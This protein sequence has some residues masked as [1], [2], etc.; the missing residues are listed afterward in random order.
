MGNYGGVRRDGLTLEEVSKAAVGVLDHAFPGVFVV[1]TTPHGMSVDTTT[2][3]PILGWYPSDVYPGFIGGR[4]PDYGQFG[5]W[6]L[7]V[8]QT[9]IAWKLNAHVYDEGVGYFDTNR[10]KEGAANTFDAYIKR[11]HRG[12]FTRAISN[13]LCIERP[14]IP[15]IL[16]PYFDGK[17]IPDADSSSYNPP[18]IPDDEGGC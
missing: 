6:L 15:D 4:H 7:F 1:S 18:P 5:Y 2:N 9:R 12:V 14:M 13:W 11:K 8:L 10:I 17:P 16:I 3:D